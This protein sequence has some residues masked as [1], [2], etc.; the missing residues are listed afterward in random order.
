MLTVC[1]IDFYELCTDHGRERLGGEH[2]LRGGVR[3]TEHDLCACG[4][5]TWHRSHTHTHTQMCA[6]KYSLCGASTDLQQHLTS[7]SSVVTRP[8]A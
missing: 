6:Y 7:Q 3:F 8:S 1:S 2:D 4:V 5:S